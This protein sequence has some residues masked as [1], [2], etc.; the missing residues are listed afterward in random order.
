MSCTVLSEILT[1]TAWLRTSGDQR[2]FGVCVCVCHI[3]VQAGCGHIQES[4]RYIDDI[5]SSQLAVMGAAATFG[6]RSSIR[7]ALNS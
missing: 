6:L 5:P 1:S 2:R 4:I 3:V 7:Q